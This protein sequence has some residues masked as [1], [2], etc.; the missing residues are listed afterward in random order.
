[1]STMIAG[2]APSQSG[3]CHRRRRAKLPAPKAPRR[4]ASGAFHLKPEVP[5]ALPRPLSAFREQ[6]LLPAVAHQLNLPW[7]K[8]LDSWTCPLFDEA[9]HPHGPVL[10]RFQRDTPS[11]D[12]PYDAL[13]N[14]DGKAFSPPAAKINKNGPASLTNR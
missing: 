1:W 3:S 10:Q 6:Q 9:A 7:S 12:P 11:A 14:G 13:K 8:R 4:V 2:Q 5:N